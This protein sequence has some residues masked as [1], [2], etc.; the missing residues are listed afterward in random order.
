MEN[1]GDI[2]LFYRTII[3]YS[4]SELTDLASEIKNNIDFL[5]KIIKEALTLQGNYE[6]NKIFLFIIKFGVQYIR[7]PFIVFLK[8]SIFFEIAEKKYVELTDCD[9]STFKFI[10]ENILEMFIDLESNQINSISAN[11]FILLYK[12]INNTGIHLFMKKK[13]AIK[14]SIF[15]TAF[16][17]HFNHTEVLLNTFAEHIKKISELS[18]KGHAILHQLLSDIKIDFE[19]CKS[20]SEMM[21]MK[22]L[23]EEK[24]KLLSLF[25]DDSSKK[26]NDQKPQII[27]S[28]DNQEIS[29]AKSSFNKNKSKKESTD[30]QPENFRNE[31]VLNEI[32]WIKKDGSFFNEEDKREFALN[33]SSTSLNNKT[34]NYDNIKNNNKSFNN[35]HQTLKNQISIFQDAAIHQNN[36]NK[37]NTIVN[38]HKEQMQLENFS[39]FEYKSHLPFLESLEIE[40]KNYSFPLNPKNITILKKTIC[41]FLNTNGGRIYLG[42]RDEDQSVIGIQMKDQAMFIF[43]KTI[44]FI[45]DQ[46]T[47][48]IKPDECLIN[49][50]PIT[51]G[52]QKQFL[53]NLFVIKIT[54][55]RGKL[56]D[57]Y[58][59]YDRVSYKRRNGKNTFLCPNEM[60]AEIIKRAQLDE[61]ECETENFEYNKKYAELS[62]NRNYNNDFK[63]EVKNYPLK[64]NYET[65]LRKELKTKFSII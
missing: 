20:S 21:I 50:I 40:F 46:I 22:S 30:K 61:K 10:L 15:Q 25:N 64:R 23:Q 48:Q 1:L 2:N 49:Y 54:I 8:D 44:Q 37:S 36:Q 53:P 13:L 9:K 11:N 26:K 58:F 27:I 6:N 14:L 28:I 43:S 35:Y 57:L 60:K 42:I 45:L 62:E 19:V 51:L 5:K 32:I 59:T 31:D 12:A 24:K 34:N 18:V 52:N 3:F 65:S 38:E 41:A 47:P 63:P 4:I 39:S 16:E 7:I 33:T 55:K 29:C 17:K 56:N